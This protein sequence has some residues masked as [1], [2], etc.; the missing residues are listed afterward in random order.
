MTNKM[1]IK[2]E[3]LFIRSEKK[4]EMPLYQ[5]T[6]TKLPAAV[7]TSDCDFKVNM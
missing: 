4:L 6:N 2:G 7:Q 1:D 3:V 5:Y